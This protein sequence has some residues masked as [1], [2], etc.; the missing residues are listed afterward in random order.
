MKYFDFTN[1]EKVEIFDVISEHFY[2]RNFGQMSKSDIDLMMFHFYIQKLER[3]CLKDDG[4]IDY[5]ECSDYKVSRELGITQQRVR[6]L[7][8]KNHLVYPDELE[9]KAAFAKLIE[10]ARYDKKTGKIVLNIP[11]PNLYIEIQ[12]FIEEQGAHVE[13]QL[14][15]KVLQIRV[16]YFIDLIVAIEEIE[17]KKKEIVRCLK[18]QFKDKGKNEDLFDERNIGKSLLDATVNITSV[19]ANLSSIISPQNLVGTALIDL[20]LK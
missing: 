5:A 20:L 19:A 12:N 14:N 18:K 4:T 6:N 11:D 2:N 9:W 16:E 3:S 1:E 7:K 10:N 15:S 8:I 13:K 17:N